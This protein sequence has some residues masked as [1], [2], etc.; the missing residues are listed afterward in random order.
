MYVGAKSQGVAC[1]YGGQ[2]GEAAHAQ[3]DVGLRCA[4]D[5]P[6]VEVAAHH[7]P[8]EAGGAQGEQRGFGDGLDGVELEVA[9]F[10]RGFGI[11]VFPGDEQD[12]FVAELLE[13]LRDGDAGEEVATGA[14]AGDDDVE[15]AGHSF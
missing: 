13:L 5:V 11:D 7:A 2:G 6:A 3:Y 12:G 8:D 10:A 1:A 14:T 15:R 9:V 4:Q